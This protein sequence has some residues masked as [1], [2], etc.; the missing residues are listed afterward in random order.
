MIS[1][2]LI[3]II[4]IE[5]TRLFLLPEIKFNSKMIH[6]YSKVTTKKKINKI[7]QWT[8]QFCTLILEG[9]RIS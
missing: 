5:K 4:E 9:S 7:N 6:I 2:I 8:F 3:E 1:S